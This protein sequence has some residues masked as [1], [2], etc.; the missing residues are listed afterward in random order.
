MPVHVCLADLRQR[1]F[2]P[3]SRSV[4]HMTPL[5]ETLPPDILPPPAGSNGGESGDGEAARA[6]ALAFLGEHAK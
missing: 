6:A 3:V 1:A 2:D 4:V 5:P